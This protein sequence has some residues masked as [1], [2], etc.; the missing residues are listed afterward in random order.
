MF[1]TKYIAYLEKENEKKDQ[2]IEELEKRLLEVLDAKLF[3]RMPERLVKEKTEKVE[4]RAQ[5]S[6]V[7]SD[8]YNMAMEDAWK[9]SKPND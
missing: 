1:N 9:R 5:S 3:N 7:P 2:R 4:D 8:A 6:S